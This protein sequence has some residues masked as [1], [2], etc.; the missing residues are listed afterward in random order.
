LAIREKAFEAGH[1]SIISSY[2]NIGDTYEALG[3][4]EKAAEY[5]EKARSN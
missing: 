2:Q 4:V 5:R 3:E 1:P